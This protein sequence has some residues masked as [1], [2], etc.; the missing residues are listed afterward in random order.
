MKMVQQHNDNAV[1]LLADLR[2]YSTDAITNTAYLFTDLCHIAMDPVN[3]QTIAIRLSAKTAGVVLE[4]T[5]KEFENEL[6]DQQ[7]RLR[8]RRETEE[9]RKMIISEAFAPLESVPDKE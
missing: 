9:I 7:L 2:V 6:I 8:L 4:Q 3:S 1:T 5:A